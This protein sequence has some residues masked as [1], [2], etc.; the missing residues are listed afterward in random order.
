MRKFK[1]SRDFDDVVVEA[2]EVSVHQSGTS[3]IF[4][5][6]NIYGEHYKALAIYPMPCIVTVVEENK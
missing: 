5:Q 4:W 1:V 2:D 6:T 3:V